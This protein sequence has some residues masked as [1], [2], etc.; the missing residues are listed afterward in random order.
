MIDFPDFN[1]VQVVLVCCTAKD[2]YLGVC[3][4]II[5]IV[6]NLLPNSNNIIILL[7]PTVVTRKNSFKLLLKITWKCMYNERYN[8]ILDKWMIKNKN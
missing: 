6:D 5:W 2:I 1:L 7:W 8:N 4:I 3:N